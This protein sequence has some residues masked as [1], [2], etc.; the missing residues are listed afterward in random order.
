MTHYKRVDAKNGRIMYFINGDMASPN[1][2][3]KSVIQLLQKN[4]NTELEFD[5]DPIT[6]VDE[7]V[8]TPEPEKKEPNI[9]DRKVDIFDGTPATHEKF[10]DGK[11][12]GLSDEN[13]KTKTVGEI[14]HQ[15]HLKEQE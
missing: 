13:Y 2:I 3:P 14:V 5:V 7:A 11:T 6:Q 10:L 8:S 1:R 15:L 9:I 12:I 4:K